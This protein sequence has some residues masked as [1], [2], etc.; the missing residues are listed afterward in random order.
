[1]KK[2]LLKHTLYAF[3]LLVGATF[4]IYY[5]MSFTPADPAAMILAKPVIYLYPEQTTNV[6]VD[7]ALGNGE[8]ICTY[9]KLQNGW[10]VTAQPDGTLTNKADG[11]E[12]AYL[13][14]EGNSQMAYDLS[15]G[16]VVK[17]SDTAAFCKKN[18][19]IWV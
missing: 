5:I 16:F 10:N 14:W 13:F 9:P 12:Y 8:F 17:G 6:F 2:R 11:R 3:C 15:T 7:V 4:V 19:P 1:M 18:W